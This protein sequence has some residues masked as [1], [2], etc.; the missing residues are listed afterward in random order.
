[1]DCAHTELPGL[2]NQCLALFMEPVLRLSLLTLLRDT[3]AQV[4][5]KVKALPG[6]AVLGAMEASSLRSL[7]WGLDLSQSC[8]IA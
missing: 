2:D 6:L 3:L 1:M 7:V 5:P 4:F 8:F